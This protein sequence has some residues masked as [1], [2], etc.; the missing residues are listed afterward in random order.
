MF[1]LGWLEDICMAV[2]VPIDNHIYSF[3]LTLTT[4]NCNPLLTCSYFLVNLQFE[5]NL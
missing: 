5:G 4:R 2:P 1:S 3:L